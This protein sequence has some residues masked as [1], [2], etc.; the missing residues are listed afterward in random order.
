MKIQE[1]S[2][3]TTGGWKKL[4]NEGL[5]TLHFSPNIRPMKE[6]TMRMKWHLKMREDEKRIQKYRL[7]T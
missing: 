4:H 1:G 2:E 7:E 3:K 6:R 5:Y